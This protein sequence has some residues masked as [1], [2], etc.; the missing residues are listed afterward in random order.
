[1]YQ[2]GCYEGYIHLV[3][4]PSARNHPVVPVAHVQARGILCVA[5]FTAKCHLCIS[6]EGGEDVTVEENLKWK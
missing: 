4:V 3:E 5:S 2:I 1:M 6:M